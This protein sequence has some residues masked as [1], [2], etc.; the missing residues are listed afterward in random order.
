[1]IETPIP[2]ASYR[3]SRVPSLATVALLLVAPA[4]FACDDCSEQPKD[5]ADRGATVGKV[6]DLSITRAEVEAHAASEL[7]PLEEQRDTV[8]RRHLDELVLERL[9]EA[10]AAARG[11]AV[12]TL[13]RQE[14]DDKLA[15]PTDEE[16]QQFYA[17]NR[18]RIRQPLDQVSDQIRQHLTAQQRQARMDELAR[19]LGRRHEVEVLW[20]PYR[21]QVA[22]V[23]APFKGPADAPVDL[24]VFSDFQCPWCSR[25]APDLELVTER[26]PEQVRLTYRHFPLNSIHPQAQAAAEAAVCAAEQQQFWSLHDAIFERQKELPTLDFRELA[27][28]LELNDSEFGSCLASDLPA[29]RVAADVA[30][31]RTLGLTSTPSLFVNGRKLALR[32]GSPIVDQIAAAVEE[33]LGR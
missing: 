12:E 9:L 6:G 11:I 24:V 10:E 16:L 26:Y 22:S 27:R 7:A 33:E 3:P 2:P 1:M 17:A 21:Y 13:R 15:P 28:G 30:A 5:A 14:V 29:S 31:A 32:N 19:E 18:A 23:E 20:Q 4:L 8:L 25:F